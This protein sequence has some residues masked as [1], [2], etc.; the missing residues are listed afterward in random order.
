[1]CVCVYTGILLSHKKNKFQSVLVRWMK[2]EPVIYSKVS[3][4]QE[5]RYILMH[6]Y[7]E[8][9]KMV[10]MNLLAGKEWRCRD[11]EQTC[12]DSGRRKEWDEWRK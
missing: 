9:R 5:N 4:K 7:M 8:S 3:L 12:A 1:M 6:M 11:R 10:L 2:L